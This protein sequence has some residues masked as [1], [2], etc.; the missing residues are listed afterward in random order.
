[1]ASNLL[2]LTAIAL[3]IVPLVRGAQG[4]FVKHFKLFYSYLGLVLARD[5]FLVA[6]YFSRPKFYGYAYWGTEPLNV[7]AG[8]ALVWEVYGIALARYPGASRVARNLLLFLFIFAFSRILVQMWNGRSWIPGRTTL[9]TELDLRIV[10]AAMLTGL[11]ALLAYYDIPLGRNLK[12]IVYGYFF[13]LVT[14][15]LNLSLRDYLGDSF[16]RVWQ[17]APAASYVVVLLFW[18]WSLWSF[19]PAPAPKPEP[20]LELDYET[21]KRATQKALRSARGHVLR[22]MRP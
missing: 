18:C 12:G 14:R 22:G 5:L 13:F 6:V 9:E 1:M 4:N 16:Q 20:S 2:W 8:C 11:I 10:Q 3:E 21:L 19:T 17:Y 7:L 15:L